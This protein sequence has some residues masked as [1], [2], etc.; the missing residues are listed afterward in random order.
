MRKEAELRG[1]DPARLVCAE[2]ASHA[3]HL[4]RHKHADLFVDTFNY[5]AHTTARDALWG[6]LPVVTKQGKQFAARVAASMLKAVGLPE[7]IT[8]TEEDYERLILQL[9]TQPER[10][11]AIKAKL[12][13]NRLTEPLFD[14]KRYTRNFERGL[15][16]S[17]DLY[18]E[19]KKPADI[20]VREDE[21]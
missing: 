6:W 19:D 21:V 2:K 4:A 10:L 18:F 13:E 16:A 8:Y 14:T 1:V 12:A 15:K 3:E 17:Y 20:W 9:A 11:S 7:L 5:N